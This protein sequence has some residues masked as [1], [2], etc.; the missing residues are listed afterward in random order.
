METVILNV[1]IQRN[2]SVETHINSP[3]P[4][5]G[6]HWE[7]LLEPLL[8]K[9]RIQC[10]SWKDEVQNL[11]I[12]AGLF[13]AVLSAFVVVSY[14][15]LQPDQNE[16][17]I[18]LLAHI[19]TRLDNTTSFLES[20]D[21]AGS[22]PT[23]SSIRVNVF[24][25]IGLVLS[26]TTALIGIVSLQWLREHQQYP[27][28]LPAR[29]K[30]AL[31]NMR[32]EG[33]AAWYVPQVF[34]SLPLLLQLALSLFFVGL[35][36]FLLAISL[37]VAIPVIIFICIPFAF[38]VLTTI[39]PAFQMFVFCLPLAKHYP[40]VPWQA[41]YK[42]TQSRLFGRFLTLSRPAFSFLTYTVHAIYNFFLLCS[43]LLQRHKQPCQE[44]VESI[45]L[46]LKYITEDV[47]Y[48][49]QSSSW[50]SLDKEWI[51]MRDAYAK[52]IFDKERRMTMASKFLSTELAPFYDLTR[53]IVTAVFEYAKSDPILLRSGYHSVEELTSS[54]IG[55]K[56]STC[57]RSIGASYNRYLQSL[58]TTGDIEKPDSTFSSLLECPH[59]EFMQDENKFIF[60]SLHLH[61][62]PFI[63][64]HYVE[65]HIRIVNYLYSKVVQGPLRDPSLKDF[66]A[67]PDRQLF[68]CYSKFP[69][70]K[71]IMAIASKVQSLSN[72]HISSMPI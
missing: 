59:V 45:A 48:A 70:K 5:E 54:I 61:P 18:A 12:F 41:P 33:L 7:R 62:P 47:Y 17:M 29:Q 14:S 36:D 60:L 52:T 55:D 69:P 37:T 34:S 16:I 58:L 9:D 32:M 11:L 19:A 8:E 4:S 3:S 13:S 35:I 46:E 53:G 1:R 10:E 64:Q 57:F 25:F 15:S 24:W 22:P 68:W 72:Y 65:L 28:S 66:V 42:S 71:K 26:L 27:N 21:L 56:A 49:L 2:G 20:I 23:P 38:L 67:Y 43:L 40:C 30:F 39:I 6:D 31:L 44:N 50:L 63:A 51:V